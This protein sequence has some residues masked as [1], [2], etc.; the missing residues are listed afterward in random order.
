M[1]LKTQS[2]ATDAGKP[3]PTN[4]S[5]KRR[6]EQGCLSGNEALM[7]YENPAGGEGRLEPGGFLRRNNY[8]DRS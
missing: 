6:M 7:E 8:G 3:E 2:F 4:A 5:H 1:K